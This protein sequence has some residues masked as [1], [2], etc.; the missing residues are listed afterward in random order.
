VRWAIERLLARGL[1]DEDSSGRIV[2]ALA[3]TFT[4]AEDGLSWTFTLRAGLTFADGET[5]RSAHV[6]DALERGLARR[7]HSTQRWL[8][9]AVEGVEAIRP[10]RPLPRLG[11]ETPDDSTLTLRLSRPDSLLPAA[12]A[13]PGVATPWRIS[14]ADSG[15]A[16][17]QGVGPYRLA[18]QQP[19]QTLILVRRAAGP[20]SLDA[21]LDTLW[22]RFAT[23]SRARAL[24]RA[25]AVDL[26]WPVP[27]GD[28]LRTDVLDG[29][30]WASLPPARMRPGCRLELV[31]RADVAP[32]AKL[33][34]RRA[35][36]HAINRPDVQR[37][38]ADGMEPFRA[39]WPGVPDFDFPRLDAGEQAAWMRRGRLGTSFHT[40]LVFDRAEVAEN[41]VGR[42]QAHWAK[43]GLSVD[44]RPLRGRR[45]A[46]ERLGGRAQLLLQ[47]THGLIEDPATDLAML[48]QGGRD[49]P[50]GRYRS[51]WRTTEFR[52]WVAPG[53]GGGPRDLRA[54]QRAIEEGT[55]VLPLGTLGWSWLERAGAGRSAFHPHFGPDFTASATP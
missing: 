53:R 18:A 52:A 47:I 36:A 2:P 26:A 50:V 12:L 32:T 13:L 55:V 51:G 28:P 54:A 44:L 46:E 40:T 11:I 37:A 10:G 45:L 15:W 25:G 17:L 31:M 49:V 23:G 33:A 8:L 5:L 29:Y 7:D 48:A 19:G 22:L 38:L 30:R 20:L 3:R 4:P 6:R 39:F 27:L 9:R 34:A 14:V 43:A 1:V 41:V 35:L 24:L 21:A 16:A 42:L